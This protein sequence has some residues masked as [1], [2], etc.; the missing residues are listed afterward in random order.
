MEVN[1]VTDG[2]M[3]HTLTEAVTSDSNK[4]QLTSCKVTLSKV[5]KMDNDNL[6]FNTIKQHDVINNVLNELSD[7]TQSTMKTRT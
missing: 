3:Q 6:V 7:K 1:L 5:I 4:E 2:R